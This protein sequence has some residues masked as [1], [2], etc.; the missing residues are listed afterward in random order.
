M[1]SRGRYGRSPAAVLRRESRS[2]SP[3][4]SRSRSSPGSPAAGLGR[5]V[6]RLVSAGESRSQSRSRVG[7]AKAL[8]GLSFRRVKVIRP[9]RHCDHLDR[10]GRYENLIRLTA[11]A[12]HPST[13]SA[14]SPWDPATPDHERRA[15]PNYQPRSASSWQQAARSAVGDAGAGMLLGHRGH[16]HWRGVDPKCRNLAD[17]RGV[18]RDLHV[19]CRLCH[20]RGV[21]RLCHRRGACRPCHG[22]VRVGLA[23]AGM[24]SGPAPSGC[25][26]KTI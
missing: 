21:C 23:I 20:S 4:E 22:R 6:P 17:A 19:R 2:R 3:P 24:R 9:V 15:S 1:T 10:T 11:S 26:S 13:C 7:R 18:G 25:S 14:T 8:S 16:G 5:G 12:R